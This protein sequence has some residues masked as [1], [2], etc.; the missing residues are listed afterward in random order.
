MSGMMSLRPYCS[1]KKANFLIQGLKS[2]DSVSISGG[3]G[4]SLLIYDIPLPGLSPSALL[5]WCCVPLSSGPLLL[6]GYLV[7]TWRSVITIAVCPIGRRIGVWPIVHLVHHHFWVLSRISVF[8]LWEHHWPRQVGCPYQPMG[9]RGSSRER[10][11]PSLFRA[12]RLRSG[13]VVSPTGVLSCP[14]SG[15]AI[16][17]LRFRLWKWHFSDATMWNW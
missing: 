4:S 11:E 14:L 8:R 2:L 3:I 9:G 15:R 13:S 7:R 17:H 10:I 12:G 1:R 16:D 5:P 6:I